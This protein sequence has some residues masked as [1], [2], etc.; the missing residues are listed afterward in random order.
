LKGEADPTAN[1]QQNKCKA[2]ISPG[3]EL[4]SGSLFGARLKVS[5]RNKG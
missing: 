1:D 2:G 5:C 4:D 3:P